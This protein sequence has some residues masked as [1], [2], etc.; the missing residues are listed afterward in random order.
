MLK[1]EHIPDESLEKGYVFPDEDD[2]LT[3]YTGGNTQ[4]AI[5]G[6]LLEN[7]CKYSNKMF[8]FW[9]VYFVV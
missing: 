1:V 6:S 3:S 4:L 9:V 2:N 7:I 5:P 8:I